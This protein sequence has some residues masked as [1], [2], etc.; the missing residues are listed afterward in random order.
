MISRRG[1]DKVR[2]VH[3]VKL[4][5]AEGEGMASLLVILRLCLLKTTPIDVDLVSAITCGG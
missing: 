2:N 4:R 3:Q 5:E 1:G